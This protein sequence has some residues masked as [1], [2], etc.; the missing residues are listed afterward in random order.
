MKPI[1]KAGTRPERKVFLH[2]MDD[3]ALKIPANNMADAKGSH[4][5]KW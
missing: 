5:L 3:R 4:L 2:I 1:H